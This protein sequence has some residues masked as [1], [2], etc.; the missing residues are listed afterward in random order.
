MRAPRLSLR[1]ASLAL[2]AG[3]GLVACGSDD[4]EPEPQAVPSASASAEPDEPEPSPTPTGP[5][6]SPEALM[7]LLEFTAPEFDDPMVQEAVDGYEDFLTQA[8]VAQGI[9]DADYPPLIAALDP[10]FVEPALSTTVI[11]EQEGIFLAGPYVETVIDGAG[12]EGQVFL[13]SCSDLSGRE[14]YMVDTG[15]FVRE[16]GTGVVPVTVTMTRAADRW[17]LS[18][19]LQNEDLVCP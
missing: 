13:T 2:V 14:L 9:G 7:A 1:V 5:D 11:N 16:A 8:M 18:N 15:E 4:D 17:V 19:Y 10:A 12:S 3:V 6:R